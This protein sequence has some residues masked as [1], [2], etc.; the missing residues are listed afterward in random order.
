MYTDSD[1]GGNRKDRKSTSGGIWGLGEHSV[2]NWSATQGAVALSTA[3]AEFYAII[4]GVTRA[5][6]LVN[7]ATS[8]LDRHQ[9]FVVD[10]AEIP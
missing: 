2:K 3:E 7:L 10:V 6:G 5:K 1:L 4:E 9:I 8:L